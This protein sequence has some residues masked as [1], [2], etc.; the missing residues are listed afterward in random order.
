VAMEVA[1]QQKP[2]L[3]VE[4][5]DET[6]EV[7]TALLEL[8]GYKVIAARDGGEGMDHLRHGLDPCVILL[9]LMMP[10]RKNG[11]E[12]RQEQLQDPNLA[13]IPV[14]V[15]SGHEEV[16]RKAAELGVTVFCQ[17]PLEIEEL[18]QLVA[19]HRRR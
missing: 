11:L 4:D 12:F 15:C 2:V 7:V 14:I 6:R 19:A 13:A 3:L 9:D 17:K 10:G 8:E 5:N 1:E 18:L 16:K